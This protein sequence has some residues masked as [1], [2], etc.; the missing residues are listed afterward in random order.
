M[1]HSQKA[2]WIIC[3][4]ILLVVLFSGISVY[5]HIRPTRG[6]P[7]EKVT[8]E[9]AQTYMEYEKDYYLVDISDEAAY[10][11][12]H[13]P[14]AV[15]IPYDSLVSQAAVMLPDKTA[16]LYVCGKSAK[17]C[18]KACRKLCGLGYTGVTYL[19]LVKKWPGTL[20]RNKE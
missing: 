12:G 10:G 18:D 3:A 1:N 20:E 16:I 11:S 2:K 14:G 9:Q 7:Y 15:N 5:K 4:C 8:M 19:G 13:I 17:K 6:L